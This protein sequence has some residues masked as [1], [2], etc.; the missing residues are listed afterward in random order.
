MDLNQEVK[1][2]KGLGPKLGK[3]DLDIIQKCK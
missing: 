1:F 2:E 3:L